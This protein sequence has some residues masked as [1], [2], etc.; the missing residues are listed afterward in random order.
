M[1]MLNDHFLKQFYERPSRAGRFQKLFQVGGL[2]T[3]LSNSII[4][5]LGKGVD[6]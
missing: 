4:K 6:I 5:K 2:T 3:N 1:G